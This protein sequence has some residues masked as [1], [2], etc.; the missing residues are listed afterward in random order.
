MA[1]FN[2][3]T[4][5]CDAD[6]YFLELTVISSAIMRLETR[7]RR[8][9]KGETDWGRQADDSQFDVDRMRL[10]HLPHSAIRKTSL[11]RL[12]EIQMDCLGH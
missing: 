1:Y 11:D 7:R 6:E 8:Q 12:T 9:G 4:V 2:G 5:F 10:Y 3:L